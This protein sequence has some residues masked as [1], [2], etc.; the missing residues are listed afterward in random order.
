MSDEPRDES[1]DEAREQP[2]AE[3]ERT[4]ASGSGPDDADAG[5]IDAAVPDPAAAEPGE[6]A[7]EADPLGELIAAIDAELG[8]AGS[9]PA[10]AEPEPE[11]PERRHLLFSLGGTRYA[12]R[13]EHLVELGLPPA[14]AMLPNVPGWMRGVANLRGDILAV[15]DL[16][17]FFGLDLPEAGSPNPAARLLVVRAGRDEVT[18]GLLVDGV[19]GLVGLDHPRPPTAEVADRVAPYLTGISEHQDRLVAVLDLERFFASPE[20]RLFEPA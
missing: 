10:A 16:A 19:H 17:E 8:V 14:T 15:V 4:G 3:R 18:A 5:G 12:V 7:A 1:I 6:P 2:G 20:V 11:G 9:G 13:L